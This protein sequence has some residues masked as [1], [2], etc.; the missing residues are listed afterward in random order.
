MNPIELKS[1]TQG[2]NV[3]VIGANGALGGAI[4]STLSALAGV[5]KVYAFSRQRE[6]SFDTEYPEKVISRVLDP[7]NEQALADA[8][9]DI[10]TPLDMVLVTTGL[11]HH[12]QLQPEKR[13]E[14]ISGNNFLQL[15]QV[16]ALVPML[17]AR[18]FLPLFHPRRRSVFAALSAR[19]G[20]ISDNRLGG[21]YSYRAS[22]AALN[23]LLKNM[24]I[25]VR[26]TRSEMIVCGLHPGTVDSHLSQPFQRNVPSDKL[27][28]AEY[29][30]ACLL[31][32][33]DQLSPEDSGQ[34][35]AW[36]G[37]PVGA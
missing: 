37:Q 10:D 36:D 29:S 20:S 8:V 13:L 7:L 27:F 18:Y 35:F 11:L 14:E 19:V 16:N 5:D 3:A 26:R 28:T 31:Q 12:G 32:V 21:W 2:M 15:M 25:E 1:F 34:V 22:K 33:I 4:V 6:N 9:A 17:V 24:A 30:A 23:M